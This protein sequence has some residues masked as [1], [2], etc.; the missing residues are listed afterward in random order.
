[1]N[2]KE[3]LENIEERLE[4]LEEKV[5]DGIKEGTYEVEELKDE[6]ERDMEALRDRI[7]DLEE[8]RD[9]KLD[10]IEKYLGIEFK[11]GYHEIKKK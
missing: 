11:E 10:A 1:M 9:T 4:E 6:T 5:H 2:K 3:E 8:I 7:E